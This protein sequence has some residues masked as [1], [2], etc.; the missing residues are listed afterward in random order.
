ME[1]WHSMTA[2]QVMEKLDSGPEGLSDGEAARR[3]ERDGPNQIS[4]PRRPPLLLR[5]LGQL[6]D[7]MI[8]VLLAAAGL[9]LAASGG[10]DWLDG[11]IILIIVAVNGV[12]SVTQEDHAHQ[13]L[14]QL[15]DLSAPMALVIRSGK[16]KRL[17][18]AALAV[19]D[20]ILLQAG[21]QVPADARLLEST[22]LRAD[23]SAMTGESAPVEKSPREGLDPDTPLGD[24]ANMLLSGTMVTAGHGRAMVVAVGMDTQMGRIAGLLLEGWLAF[25]ARCVCALALLFIGWVVSR[26]MQKSLFPRLLKRSWHFAFTHPLLES[27]ARP[28][29]RIAWYTGMYLALRSLPW[30]IPGLAALL[31]KAYRMMLVFLIGTGFYHASG[32]A[33][34]LLASSSEEVRTN[35]T[36]LTLLD[37]VYKVAVVVLCGATIAQESGLPVG[38]VVASAGLIGLTISLAAQDMA[39]NF[40]SG[41]VILLDKPFSIGDWITVGDVEGEVVDINFRSTKVRAVDNSIYILTNSTVSS[42]TINNATLRN[43]RLYRFTLGVTY[44]TT[45]PQ[46]EKLMADL[47]AMLKASPDTYEDTAFV[48]MTGFGDSSIN[49]MVSAY[50]RTADLGVFLRM[51]NDLN[52]NIMDVMKA[53]GVDFAFPSTTV[54]LAKEN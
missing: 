46:L 1:R 22:R 16:E 27:F 9:S 13:A 3:L 52:L 26:W 54:Y 36:L 34:L 51:Q 53:D 50:L 7:P 47:D 32:I 4:P 30:A 35:R 28:T 15:R 8:L 31:L 37:K 29:A 38:S 2:R 42:A 43:R 23:E 10:R 40:F 24:R 21:D 6:Q 45:R 48:R 5:L 18:A 39:K 49:L 25:A 14:E 33:A 20:V 17:P 12:L 41:V 44:D 11:A 19:G